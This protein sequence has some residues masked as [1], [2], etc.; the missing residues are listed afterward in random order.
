MRR[1]M[2]PEIGPDGMRLKDKDAVGVS[3]STP[4]H[5]L[6]HLSLLSFLVYLLRIS[7]LALSAVRLFVR[8][9]LAPLFAV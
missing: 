5:P 2:H 4:S 8:P 7:S 1:G 9:L 3:P 6:L